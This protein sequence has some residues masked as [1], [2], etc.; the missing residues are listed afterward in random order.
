MPDIKLLLGE[1]TAIALERRLMRPFL[2]VE[3]Q[4][5]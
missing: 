2:S 1:V 5:L 3:H 4:E